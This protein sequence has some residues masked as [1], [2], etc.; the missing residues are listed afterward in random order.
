MNKKIVYLLKKWA[1]NK[2]YRVRTLEKEKK[3][4]F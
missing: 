4:N 2:I 1:V 3:K